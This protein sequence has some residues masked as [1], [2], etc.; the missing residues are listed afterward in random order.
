MIR[1]VELGFAV[2]EEKEEPS[3][4]LTDITQQDGE[5]LQVNETMP[6]ARSIFAGYKEFINKYPA[7]ADSSGRRFDPED[8]SST[9]WMLD[10]MRKSSSEEKTETYSSLQLICL[11]HSTISPNLLH[12][13]VARIKHE[14][15][16]RK[17]MPLAV[18]QAKTL[19]VF[20]SLQLIEA[21]AATSPELPMES[22]GL[23]AAVEKRRSPLETYFSKKTLIHDAIS[24]AEVRTGP[25]A[26]LKLMKVQVDR[27]LLDR[28][29]EG[30]DGVLD[31]GNKEMAERIAASLL[32]TVNGTWGTNADIIAAGPNIKGCF[33]EQVAE[34]LAKMSGGR[35]KHVPSLNGF[36]MAT[37][38]LASLHHVNALN[39]KGLPSLVWSVDQRLSLG[40]ALFEGRAV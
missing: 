37:D 17:A 28:E 7:L 20:F 4:A 24:F 6:L 34:A 14:L 21:W 26:G 33:A 23:L 2:G 3:P 40:A 31:G 38:P 22:T 18:G 27:P 29:D 8:R 36:Y 39:D 10:T 25:G 35:V 11:T 12:S 1:I 13:H 19:A 5:R 30:F 15:G 9:A 16:A 32:E